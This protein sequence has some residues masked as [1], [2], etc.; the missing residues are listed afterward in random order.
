MNRI[1]HLLLYLLFMPVV[2]YSQ[3]TLS[4]GVHNIEISGGISAYYNQRFLKE[5][6]TNQQKNRHRLRD[7]QIQIEGRY[8]DKVEYE[9]QIDFADL[10]RAAT[11]PIDGENPG[12]MD[13]YVI[14]KGLEFIDIQVGYGKT[15]Y[16]RSSLVPFIYTPYWQ[17]A[18]MVRGDVFARRDVGI[19][20]RRTFWKQRIRVQG[21]VYNG[22][23]EISLRGDN[24]PSGN[25]EYIGRVDFAYPSRYR[26]RDIDDKVSPIPMFNLGANVRH[27]N[28]QQPVGGLLPPASVGEYGIKVIDGIKTGYGFDISAQYMGFSAQF[29]MHQFIMEPQNP[30]NF[31]FQGL[32]ED[33]HEGYVRAGGYYGQ[34]NYFSREWNSIFSG[35]YEALNINDLAEGEL[36]RISVAY[37]YMFSGFDTMLKIQYFRVLSEEDKIDA[38]RWTEQIRIGMQYNF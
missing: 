22:I 38:L 26:Y 17:R 33:F 30:Q 23:G 7:A 29:E 1:L 10:T 2:S 8:R 6:E 3:L 34:L 31:L 37:A 18:E 25:L 24:D 5:G 4:N 15:P 32:S 12:L 27:T 21:G 28:K 36:Q 9:F 20:L 14:F 19:T 13:A 16:S 35:R 11:G